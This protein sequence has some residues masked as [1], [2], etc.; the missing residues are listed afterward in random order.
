MTIPLSLYKELLMTHVYKVTPANHTTV[1]F[2]AWKTKQDSA[3]PP[4]GQD[5][6]YMMQGVSFNS[7]LAPHIQCWWQSAGTIATH[8][9]S[10]VQ[11]AE[12][13]TDNIH[14][15]T[16]HLHEFQAC[17]HKNFFIIS[18][19]NAPTNYVYI[20]TSYI[21]PTLQVRPSKVAPDCVKIWHF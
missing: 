2:L 9:T 14:S 13:T 15:Y 16:R 8:P 10:A 3:L 7:H 4:A 1:H 19:N 20:Y 21:S 11:S 6:N 18:Y 17:L 12:S 5:E